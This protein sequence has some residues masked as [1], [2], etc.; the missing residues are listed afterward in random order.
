MRVSLNLVWNVPT[1]NTFHNN[2][3]DN[4]VRGNSLPRE[5]RIM[6]NSRGWQ[7][8]AISDV[9]NSISDLVRNIQIWSVLIGTIAPSNSALN[10]ILGSV[11]VTR[12]M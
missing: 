3:C 4:M 7:V 2:L 6:I 11:H 1:L 12:G 10:T 8:I 9:G 5:A